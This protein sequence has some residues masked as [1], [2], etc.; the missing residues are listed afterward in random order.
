MNERE[1]QHK[2]RLVLYGGNQRLDLDVSGAKRAKLRKSRQAVTPAPR[3]HGKRKTRPS[4]SR[5]GIFTLPRQLAD[6]KALAVPCNSHHHPAGFEAK[7]A[8]SGSWH[9]S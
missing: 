3:F 5:V 6:D 7:P 8:G 4:W 2:I 9:D 1:Q